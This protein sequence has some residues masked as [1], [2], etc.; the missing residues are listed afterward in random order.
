MINNNFKIY[1]LPLLLLMFVSSQI[2]SQNMAFV[3]DGETSYLSG[4]VNSGS[5]IFPDGTK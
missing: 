5:Q 1:I 4:E 3:F 2:Y